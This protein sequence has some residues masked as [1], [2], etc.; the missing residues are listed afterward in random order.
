MLEPYHLIEFILEARRSSIIIG[1]VA[2][3][4]V[5]R[6]IKSILSEQL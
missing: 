2:S 6:L 4:S 1:T 5:S 3:F